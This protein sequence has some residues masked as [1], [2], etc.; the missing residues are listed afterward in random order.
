MLLLVVGIDGFGVGELGLLWL[1]GRNFLVF[2]LEAA[3]S[4]ANSHAAE[5]KDKDEEQDNSTS[6]STTT[7][8][9]W[10][11]SVASSYDVSN[12]SVSKWLDLSP[13]GHI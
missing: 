4:E 13:V 6:C 1:G 10:T 11:I 5:Q 12:D 2:P 9:S 7:A 3:F 8:G